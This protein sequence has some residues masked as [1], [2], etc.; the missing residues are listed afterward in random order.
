MHTKIPGGR[1]SQ[2]Q[3]FGYWNDNLVLCSS[4]NYVQWGC[5]CV[6]TGRLAWLSH[7]HV[8]CFSCW[9]GKQMTL[10]SFWWCHSYLAHALGEGYKRKACKNL[11]AVVWV[12][13]TEQLD[14]LLSRPPTLYFSYIDAS[15]VE[16]EYILD[17]LCALFIYLHVSKTCLGHL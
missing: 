10:T 16:Q 3:N 6:C 7:A 5:Q 2:V 15:H 9:N 4:R 13:G 1:V 14:H 12:S 17:E 11:R 8:Q